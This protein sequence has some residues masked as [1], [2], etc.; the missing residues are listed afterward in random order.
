MA[1]TCTHHH[2]DRVAVRRVFW[3]GK[4]PASFCEAHTSAALRVAEAMSFH[5]H[6]EPIEPA[7]VLQE[8]VGR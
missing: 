4:P 2:C 7:M 1:M 6:T 5:L 3:P 8:G